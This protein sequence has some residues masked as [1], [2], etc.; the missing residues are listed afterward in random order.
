MRRITRNLV[1]GL[2]AVVVLLL[3]LGALPSYLAAGDP[4][5]L[6]ATPVENASDPT[7]DATN[8]SERRFPYTT[9]A[10]AAAEN[11]SRVGHAEP[12][13]KGPFGVKEAFAHSPFDELRTLEQFDSPAD[14]GNPVLVETDGT[15]YRIA[16][17]RNAAVAPAATAD[18]GRT[19]T[20][21]TG[22]GQ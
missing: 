18:P 13:W 11:G 19:A 20:A 16:I 14:D 17:S 4:Y 2:V 12:Y 15:V 22:G 8:L 10:I 9:G 1:V 6:T 21:A 3:A 7:V 5:Y